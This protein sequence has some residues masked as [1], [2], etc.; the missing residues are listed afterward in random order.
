MWRDF[1]ALVKPFWT[2]EERTRAMILG[3]V[4]AV[5]AL[6]ISAVLSQVTKAQG[7][8]GD[9]L[10][11]KSAPRFLHGAVIWLS[12]A[13]VFVVVN[14]Y[15]SYYQQLLN[16]RWRHWM[17]R[18]FL[19]TYL[20]NRTHYYWRFSSD[21]TD[22]P[23]QRIAEDVRD[24]VDKTLGLTLNMLAWLAVLATY[25]VILWHLSQG[26]K[27]PIGGRAIAIPGFLVWVSIIWSAIMMA[28]VHRVGHRLVELNVIKQKYEADFRFYLVR[29]RENSESI[30]FSRGEAIEEK[31]L[32]NRFYRIVDNALTINTLTKAVN[33]VSQT[34]TTLG[35]NLGLFVASPLYFGGLL[36]IGG[37]FQTSS[38]FGYVQGALAFIINSYTDIALL[39]A[40]IRRLTEF[41][42]TSDEARKIAAEQALTVESETG[43]ADS[44]TISDLTVSLPDGR[45]LTSDVSLSLSPGE[46]LLISGPSG[47]G[48]STLLR[49]IAG[50][51]P[52]AEGSVRLPANFN[53][54][55]G[56]MV[57]PQTPYLPVGTLRA[58]LSYPADPSSLKDVNWADLLQKLRLEHLLPRLDDEEN[59]S[60]FLS[61]GE[62][63]RVAFARVLLRRPRWLFLDEATSALDEATEKN[64]MRCCAPRC[65]KRLFCLLGTAAAWPRCMTL[66]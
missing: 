22:N 53:S 52:Y 42:R 51:W 9:A 15:S 26:M 47:A 44:L 62:Q 13:A 37:L 19:Q 28:L 4:S 6:G 41:Q 27:V 30:A 24:F 7:I 59:W 64:F 23:D 29:V 20:T 34:N 46:S 31:A 32:Q 17:T 3:T 57:L 55:N 14:I 65:P 5:L 21:Y 33:A 39:N 60:Q 50:I 56:L 49:A 63:Q 11:D 2:N 18:Q 10:Q 43:P 1:W 61:G 12:W 54:D 40:I 35:G 45:A 25:T 38:A 36:K 58:V 8:Y 66:L 48:K 16:I